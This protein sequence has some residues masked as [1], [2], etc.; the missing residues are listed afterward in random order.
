MT[1]SP[2]SGTDRRDLRDEV[3]ELRRLRKQLRETEQELQQREEEL[4]VLRGSH[5]F[6]LTAPLR[7]LRRQLARSSGVGAVAGGT[8]VLAEELPPAVTAFPWRFVRHEAPERLND[9]HRPLRLDDA[10]QPLISS[11]L[12]NGDLVDVADCMLPAYHG[13]LPDPLCVAT[14]A[15]R[16]FRNELAF[17]ASVL[18]L[19]A[20]AWKEQLG[21]GADFV[22]IDGSWE[23]EGQWGAGFG[24][25][26]TSQ[27]RLSPLLEH[28]R[29]QSIPVV[30]WAR[31][32]A[33][34]LERFHWLVPQVDRVYAIDAAGQ[35]QLERDHPGRA[36]GVLA[37]A[38][39]PAL[40]NPVRSYGLR[41]CGAAVA[42]TVLFDGWW[43]LSS[44]LGKDPV[45]VELADRL[46]V[47]DTRGDYSWV[48]L[49]DSR[50]YAPRALGSIT[51]LEKSALL[52]AGAAEL[53]V[54]HPASRPWRQATDMLRAA[55]SG[56]AV[57]WGGDMSLPAAWAGALPARPSLEARNSVPGH[58]A[59]LRDAH[60]AFRRVL[61][62][63][64]LADRLR[65]IAADLNLPGPKT[66]EL[67]V[68]HL[69][70]TMRPELLEHCLDRYR[71]D[72]YPNREL[73]VVLHGNDIDTR[74][75]RRLLREGEAVTLLK[76]DSARS[77]GECLNMAV[78]HTDA[79][80]WMKLD[81][82][83]H[84]GPGYTR[85]FMLYRRAIRAPLMGKPPAF[86]HLE[87]ADELRWDPQW[88]SYAN[89]LHNPG[90]ASSALVAGGT[91]AGTREVI[92]TI[93]F[94]GARRG[95]SDSEFI[96]RCLAD[97]YPVLAT[98]PFNFA[99]YRSGDDGFHTWKVKDGELK[100][101]TMLLGDR[102]VID[103]LVFA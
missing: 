48:R 86:V 101:G 97:G 51:A 90:E 72:L 92:E 46:R 17:D 12:R 88:A 73:V 77:L 42:G 87:A 76:A 22:L 82:D 96:E 49:Q 9:S 33:D 23:P 81:D 24:G 66:G 103:K 89:L 38:V 78:A 74:A 83:D 94:S 70:V 71:T 95:G 102:E 10:L 45:L 64:C 32:D 56:A 8:Q 30:L 21:R 57:Y 34:Q 1:G 68:A 13:D 47:V 31:E 40:F 59:A 29:Q 100:E 62:E 18:P 28:C 26:P 84:Y 2:P 15:C 20:D 39:Q 25:S 80:F 65:M 16:E 58:P 11:K 60:L 19:H 53:F 5:S 69:L 79:P 14:I 54:P 67:R 44:D 27:R 55:A 75:A 91:L 41:E 85:D 35:Q 52:R 50:G 61:S 43:A 37:V 3:A 7:W 99:R 93:G 6:K 98:D 63:H 4:A 36:H